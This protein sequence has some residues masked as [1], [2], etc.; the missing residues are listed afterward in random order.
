MAELIVLEID[1]R[2]RRGETPAKQEYLERFPAHADVISDVLFDRERRTGAFVPPTLEEMAERFPAL[3]IIG[4][5][6]AGGMGAVYKARQ[7]G[8]D[9]IVALKSCLR[10]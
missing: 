10:N 2:R 5:L 6:G 3:E 1:H 7:S 8:L 9:R 4:L